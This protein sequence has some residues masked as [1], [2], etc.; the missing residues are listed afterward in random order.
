MAAYSMKVQSKM[1]TR[2]SIRR[3][4]ENEEKEGQQSPQGR[5]KGKGYGEQTGE[6]VGQIVVARIAVAKADE[7]DRECEHR[8]GEDE[9]RK[10]EVQLGDDPHRDAAAH[11]GK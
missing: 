3:G 2:Y 7:L 10:H 9:R 4:V 8:D 5:R 11:H 6:F 1:E